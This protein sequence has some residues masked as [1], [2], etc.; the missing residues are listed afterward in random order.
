MAGAWLKF[1]GGDVAQD[2]VFVLL[3]A[4]FL[5]A[6]QQIVRVHDDEAAG[7][8]GERVEHGLR[9]ANIVFHVRHQGTEAI[10]IRR[11]LAIELAVVDAAAV[12]VV[13]DGIT[14]RVVAGIGIRRSRVAAASRAGVRIGGRGVDRRRRRRANA[15]AVAARRA[16]AA[17]RDSPAAASS[18]QGQAGRDLRGIQQNRLRRMQ[19]AE[20]SERPDRRTDQTAHVDRIDRHVGVV[21]GVDGGGEFGRILG[22]HAKSGGE[23]DQRFA[24]RNLRQS[25]GHVAKSAEDAARGVIGEAAREGSRGAVGGGVGEFHAIRD[26]LQPVHIVGEVLRDA[27]RAAELD[28]RHQLVRAGVGFDELRGGLPGINLAGRGGAGVIEEENQVMLLRVRGIGIRLKGEAG[29]RLFF[30]VFPDL[31]V[32]LGQAS[33][34]VAFL[35]GDHRIHQ[36]KAAFAANR[37]VTVHRLLGR[38]GEAVNE[39]GR[40]DCER[41]QKVFHEAVS[42]RFI[43]TVF[44]PRR[45]AR[46]S[47]DLPRPAGRGGSR[48]FPAAP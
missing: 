17:G 46:P 40:R 25:F 30:T 29:D 13:N 34:V 6:A 39:A 14:P 35:I 12:C 2:V 7:A 5:Q 45:F 23:E 22:G 20:R 42:I 41:F 4:D 10:L 47:S 19:Q 11:V 3:F 48:T 28:D 31:E 9:A 27:Q 1:L 21:A 16:T 18:L 37:R 32:L 33:D 36:H 24:A 38:G 15:S 26:L 8:A 43:T 44:P